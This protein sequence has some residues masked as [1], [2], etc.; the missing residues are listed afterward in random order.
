[1][2]HFKVSYQEF[3][4]HSFS[5]SIAVMCSPLVDD[6]CKKNNLSFTE[7]IQPFCK[8]QVEASY[9]EPSGT[10]ITLKNFRINVSHVDSRPPQP[11]MARKFLNESVSSHVNEKTTTMT[12]GNVSLDVPVSVPWFDAWRDT[13]LQVQFPSDH[14]FTKHYLACILVVSSAEQSPMDRLQHISAQLQQ[15]QTVSPAKLPKW[16]SPG[17][18]SGGVLRYHVLLHDNMDGNTPLAES[19]YETMK[20][21]YGVNNSFFLNINSQA[22]PT[23]DTQLP[24]PWSQ[25][26]TR[27]YHSQDTNEADEVM[28][29]N[30]EGLT[31]VEAAQEA[32]ETSPSTPV[33]MHP[34]SPVSDQLHNSI[35]DKSVVDGV[36]NHNWPVTAGVHGGC[37]TADDLDRL[38][39]FIS[40]F[41][42]SCLVPHVESQISQLTDL[43]SNKKGMSRSFLSATKR[44]F[45][46]K[47]GMPNTPTTNVTYTNDSTELQLRRLGDL[48][49]MFGA[50]SLA[51]SAYHAAKRDFNGDAAWLHYA[52]ALEMAAL[53][54]FMQPADPTRKAFEYAEESIMTYLNS[55]RMPQFATRATLF[56]SECLRGRGMWGEAAKQLIRMTSEDS[57][58]RSALLLEQAAYCFLASPR[59]PMPRKY[60]FHLVLAGHRFSKAG[61]KRHSLR[62]Y[63]QAYQVYVNKS[64]SLAEDHIHHTIGRQA[65]MLKQMTEAADAFAQLL[66]RASRQSATQQAT[67]LREYLNT[68][69]QL[70]CETGELPILPLPVVDNDSIQVLL[71]KPPQ[72][73][74]MDNFECYASG[75]SFDLQP[76]DTQRWNKLE[77]QLVSAALRTQPMIFTPTVELLNNSTNN[78]NPPTSYAGEAISVSVSLNNPLH[79]TVTLQNMR[80]LWSFTP[81]DSGASVDNSA[82]GNIAVATTRVIERLVMQPDTSS[83]IILQVVPLQVGELRVT[84]VA[85]QLG[86][87]GEAVVE[88]RQVLVPR[89]RRQRVSKDSGA[90]AYAADNRLRLNI[91]Q[92]APAIRVSFKKLQKDMLSGELTEVAVKIDNCGGVPVTKLL[93]VCG[94]PGVVAVGRRCAEVMEVPLDTP[95][96]PGA[97]LEVPMRVRAHDLKGSYTV[98]LLFYYESAQNQG[99]PL[100]RLV[101]HSWPI[102][103][104][105][106]LQVCVTTTRSA[107]AVATD[108]PE[109]LNLKLQVQNTSQANDSVKW[110]MCVECAALYSAQWQLTLRGFHPTAVSLGPQEVSHFLLKA[111][112]RSS[113]THDP[114]VSKLPL[115][116]D[117]PLSPA[118]EFL[119]HH[120]PPAGPTVESSVDLQATFIVLWK[121]TV[122]LRG[123]DARSA[124]GQ[125]HVTLRGIGESSWWPPPPPASVPPPLTPANDITV[126][127]RLVTYSLVPQAPATPHD[128]SIDRVCLIPVDLFVRNCSNCDVIVEVQATRA[129]VTNQGYMYSPHSCHAFHWVGGTLRIVDLPPHGCRS[130]K[131]SA[132]V[133]AP[134]AYNL[135]SHLVLRARTT[136]SD[137]TPQSWRTDSTLVVT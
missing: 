116:G 39:E 58:L 22:A 16:F 9:R 12:V 114:L 60:A 5:P 97:T 62:C 24:D 107:V 43:I 21:T 56:A 54:L 68:Q 55:C 42:V 102:L 18:G 127:Q 27:R 20:T 35:H 137:F 109:S 131:M 74:L 11:T 111:V 73:Q 13:F 113:V 80:L 134:G 123:G 3:I 118:A 49:F 31:T 99:K 103:V 33:I 6:I 4:Q 52:G 108:Q 59:P 61:Q 93:A 53:S 133:G 121:A 29:N 88:G 84:G 17:G 105:D 101:R 85:Y 32:G 51:F 25:F 90:V 75:V 57:D 23:S 98:D 125:H 41:C 19:L 64:W 66:P 28:R 120:Q 132:A 110:V 86:G 83:K 87:E 81:C 7:L 136:S 119:P 8:L 106:S 129:P 48:C 95:L 77:E 91:S 2:S 14:E 126:K 26:I 15:M 117:T 94:T 92:H 122:E 115:V 38:R 46:S 78:V 63:R 47:P 135:G 30:L 128:F 37:L 104:H 40:C 1:M 124:V 89:G 70:N 69:Q 44:W 76:S 36:T 79:I 82:V 45:G 10:I 72:P 50:Y 100:Y 130:V 112:R 71:G 67:F 34:L 65:T 96:V